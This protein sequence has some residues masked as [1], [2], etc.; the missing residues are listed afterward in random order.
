MQ[1]IILI[2]L[3]GGFG[4]IS[5][6]ALSVLLHDPSKTFPFGTFFANIF[7]CF[8]LG[9]IAVFAIKGCVNEQTRLLLIT[10]FC[11][12]FSTFS[13]FSNETFLLLQQGKF[14]IAILYTGCSLVFSLVGIWAGY[15]LAEKF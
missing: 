2:F 1:N 6:Y 13:T 14:T 15:I 9:F 5:R 8:I 3:G 12:G 11:G 7:A 4:S 10:G